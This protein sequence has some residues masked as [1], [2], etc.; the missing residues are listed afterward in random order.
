MADVR[1]SLG[2][3]VLTLACCM[4]GC[5]PI[6]EPAPSEVITVLDSQAILDQADSY[7]ESWANKQRIY[8]LVYPILK[9]NADLCGSNVVDEMGFEWLTLNDLTGKLGR[10]AAST[11]GVSTFPF[12]NVVVPGSSAYLAGLRPG[13]T[14][15]SINGEAIEEDQLTNFP[16]TMNNERFYRWK[17]NRILQKAVRSSPTINI[18]YQ[19]DQEMHETELHLA[20]RCD[21]GVLLLDSDEFAS[22]SEGDTIWISKGLYEHAQSDAEF[23][24]M[25]AHELAHR[26]LKH[27]LHTSTGQSVAEGIDTF[28]KVIWTIGAIGSALSGDDLGAPPGRIF[29]AEDPD[30]FF[31]SEQELEADYLGMYILVRAGID[32]GESAGFWSRAPHPSPLFDVHDLEEHKR[33]ANLLATQREIQKKKDENK[34]LT[35]N[36]SGEVSAIEPAIGP[37]PQ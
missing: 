8:G 30:R 4:F 6:S 22:I 11:L 35:P 9:E 14:L 29:A 36:E 32:T 24:T 20:K 33:L 17:F 18:R 31:N 3:L 19:R 12:I 23:Q 27:R 26:I 7:T 28:L 34:P 16:A 25:V 1:R 2:F 13:D 15:K 10:S 37:S 5:M 21:Y